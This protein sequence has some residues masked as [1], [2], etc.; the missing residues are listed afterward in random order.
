VEAAQAQY[1]AAR[2]SQADVLMAHANVAMLD[3][4][5]AELQRKVRSARILLARWTGEGAD[6]ALGPLPEM[7]RIDMGAHDSALARHPQVEVLARAQELAAA[8][9]RLADANRSP[10]WSVE[11]AY[12]D[13]AT[14]FGDMVSLG[15][16]IP[17]PWDRAHR[18][19]RELAAR[20]AL[21]E[22]ARAAR[23]EGLRQHEAELRSMLAEWES[24]RSRVVRYEREIVPLASGRVEAVVAAYRGGKSSQA[25]VIAARR[26]ELDARL[27]RLALE[28]E[29]AR[30]RA[31]LDYLTA[32]APR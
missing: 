24:N 20:L 23:D 5:V 10:D 22:Q 16:S 30:L 2:G 7:A 15:V 21:A 3:D 28:A 18:Q 11:L 32:E 27:Q 26:A 12:S 19:D 13:R 9:A 1:G 6:R 25:E 17:L 14:R 31:Q 8:E 29:T 4:R